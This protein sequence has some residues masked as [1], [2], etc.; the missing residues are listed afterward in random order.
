MTTTSTMTCGAAPSRRQWSDTDDVRVA[1]WLQRR[2]LN[3]TPLVVSR[4]VGVVARENVRHS[5]R[6]Y[7]DA[8]CWDG[9]PRIERWTIPCL[10][11][12]DTELNRA[13]GALWMISAVARIYRPGVKADHMLILEGPQGVK[14]STAL[15]TLAGGDWFTDELPEVGSKDAALHM[16]GVW[17]IEIA[18]LDAIGRAEVS[19]IKAFLTRTVDRFRPPYG[20]HTVE[21]PR[22]CVFAGTVI[23]PTRRRACVATSFFGARSGESG[24]RT[25]ASTA[26]ARSGASSAA[27]GSASRVAPS[28]V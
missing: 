11:A 18:E 14:K 19:R 23:R 28:P 15:K 27:K 20:R 10:G 6:D 21:V 13:F 25:S 16:Q 3:V 7:L 24:R 9:V 8:L 12:E 5:V 26:S 4:S 22:Q 17:I 2:E 1:E